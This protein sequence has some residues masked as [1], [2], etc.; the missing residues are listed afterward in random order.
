MVIISRILWHCKTF[1][2]QD[3]L[4]DDMFDHNLGAI[5][6]LSYKANKYTFKFFFFLLFLPFI[7][8]LP[9]S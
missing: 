2:G 6:R 3:S 7:I 4:S 8:T 5:T 1:A 9:L